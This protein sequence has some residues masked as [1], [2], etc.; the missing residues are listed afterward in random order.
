M[1]GGAGRWV[2]GLSLLVF[3]VC[4]TYAMST[5]LPYTRV[6]TELEHVQRAVRFGGTHNL[7]PQYFIHPPFFSYVLLGLYGLMYLAGRATGWLHNTQEYEQ[8]FFTDP[9]VFLLAGRLLTL[10]L[11]LASLLL[12]HQVARRLFGERVARWAVAFMAITP[13]VVT[14]AHY[15]S[16]DIAALCLGFLAFF[17]MVEVADTGKWR[18]YLGAGFALGLA[19][20]TKYNAVLLGPAFLVAHLLRGREEGTNWVRCLWSPKWVG[21]CLCVVAG[22]VVGCPYA[23]L[24]HQ[25][26]LASFTEQVGRVNVGEYQFASWK[27]DRPGWWYILLVVLPFA[28][29]APVAGLCLAGLAY[30]VWRRERGDYL[31]LAGIL[32]FVIYMGS[33]TVIKPRYFLPVVPLL[34]IAGMRALL[35]FLQRVRRGRPALTGVVGCSLALMPLWQTWQFNRQIT[36]PLLTTQAKRWVEAHL[37]AGTSIAMLPS[38]PLTPNRAAIERQLA[39]VQA[40]GHE[41]VR[42]MRLLRYVDTVP[43]TYNIYELAFPWRD[44]FD[45]ADFDFSRLRRAGVEYVITATHVRDYL[46]DPVRYTAQVVF[47][48]DVQRSCKPIKHFQGDQPLIDVGFPYAEE[49]DIYDCRG[50]AG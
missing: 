50:A 10:G 39:R 38:V 22:F 9:T 35:E 26:F 33:W 4:A 5:D 41:G 6:A 12:C 20:A 7:N 25:T 30:S 36:Q 43:A 46:A 47:Y 45:V 16:A 44:D 14:W 31:L 28:L 29:S 40:R 3:I 15:G 8:V 32:P 17:W 42:L 49:V 23:V 13:V 1:I 27:T 21:G 34:L 24:D 48:H 18:Y 37:P 19:S 11:G 2:L